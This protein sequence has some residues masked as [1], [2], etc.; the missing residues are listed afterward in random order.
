MSSRNRPNVT[1][2]PLLTPAIRILSQS[3]QGHPAIMVKPWRSTMPEAS[4]EVV[5]AGRRATDPVIT[6]PKEHFMAKAQADT[7]AK[8]FKAASKTIAAKGVVKPKHKPGESAPGVKG[9]FPQVGVDKDV[10]GVV[11]SGLPSTTTTG[12][13]DMTEAEKTLPQATLD[14]QAATQ[15]KMAAKLEK[16][17]AAT[18]KKADAEAAKVAK[19]AEREAAA[20]LTKEQREAKAAEQAEAR[21]AANPDGKRTYFGSMLTL[22]DKV[23]AGAY[24]KGLNGQL[25]SDDDVATTLE[26]VKP[27]N[28]VKLIMEVLG[29]TV[30]P[31][32]HLNIGQQSMN[33]RNKLRGA[34]RAEEGAGLIVVPGTDTEPPVRATITRLRE[35]RDVHG[36]ATEEDAVTK[37]AEAKKAKQEAADKAKAEKE[38]NKAKIAAAKAE[39]KAKPAEAAPAA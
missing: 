11:K 24:V 10:G 9:I 37:K 5:K 16:Q 13:S 21:K 27:E 19:A 12:D 30:N 35:L 28:V 6:I 7:K 20:K 25:R 33:L 34:L 29:L 23:K 15:A 32:T 39:A 36:Y 4:V 3:Q 14:K 2:S 26:V 18:K 38:A 17:A 22:S 1:D 8:E 31:Y